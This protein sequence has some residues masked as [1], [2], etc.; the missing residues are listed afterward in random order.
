[1][2]KQLSTENNYVERMNKNV[3][4]KFSAND[5]FLESPLSGGAES[6]KIGNL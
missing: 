5:A 2:E 3:D 1:M 6:R 4:I